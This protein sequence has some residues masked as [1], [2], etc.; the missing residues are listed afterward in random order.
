[1][2]HLWTE[3]TRALFEEIVALSPERTISIHPMT[4]PNLLARSAGAAVTTDAFQNEVIHLDP[5]RANEYAFAHE[6]SHLQLTRSGWPCM[7]RFFASDDVATAIAD[8]LDNVFD[9][10]IFH[11]R[12][13]QMGIDVDARQQEFLEGFAHWPE[14]NGNPAQTFERATMILEMLLH[15]GTYA[16]RT[17]QVVKSRDKA[18]LAL[19]RR[20]ALCFPKEVGPVAVRVSFIEALDLLNRWLEQQLGGHQRLRWRIGVTPVFTKHELDQPFLELVEPLTRQFNLAKRTITCTFYVLRR[21]NTRFRALVHQSGRID[22]PAL[23]SYREA[24]ETRTVRG[25][26]DDSDLVKAN[27]IVC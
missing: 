1:M 22:E 18:A 12:L 6:L 8:G 27:Y 13:S 23:A 15:G 26:L 5:A 2:E 11:P 10:A 21:D 19:A 7:F 24:W 9:H 25:V 20:L 17:I 3:R 4:D 16:T 14:S